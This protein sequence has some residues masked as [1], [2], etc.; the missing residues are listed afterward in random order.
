MIRWWLAVWALGTVFTAPALALQ[1]ADP[2][3]EPTPED[4]LDCA[5]LVSMLLAAQ[6]DTLSPEQRIGL[7]S[8]MTYFVGRYEAQRG[9]DVDTAMV[10]RSNAFPKGDLAALS[11]N[12][13]ARMKAVGDRMIVAGNTVSEIENKDNPPAP[14]PQSPPE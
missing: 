11:K 12:C 14:T 10:E 6:E 8:G 1:N 7:V 5:I 13:S 2:V 4:D 9:A 3:A